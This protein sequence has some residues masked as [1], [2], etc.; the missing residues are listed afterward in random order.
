MYFKLVIRITRTRTSIWTKS[1]RGYSKTYECYHTPPVYR[2][3]L[4]YNLSYPPGYTFFWIDEWTI[5]G[6]YYGKRN[7]KRDFRRRSWSEVCYC[8]NKIWYVL[9]VFV[10]RISQ[11]VRDQRMDRDDEFSDSEDEG[12]GAGRRN[13]DDY[14]EKT[15][16]KYIE[17]SLFMV[18]ISNLFFRQWS[19]GYGVTHNGHT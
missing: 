2:F 7:T 8:N 14:R 1:R 4:I 17:I 9:T 13:K 18:I 5:T 19:N 3:E 12:E 15:N 11:D 6:W 10:H 16:G